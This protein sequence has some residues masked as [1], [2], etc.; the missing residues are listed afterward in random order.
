[1]SDPVGL[2]GTIGT[3][4]AV[5]IAVVALAGILPAYLL[6]KKSRTEIVQ[7]LALVDDPTH[8]FISGGIRL[9][10]S[11][12]TRKSKCPTSLTRRGC[13][14]SSLSQTQVDSGPADRPP[15]GSTSHMS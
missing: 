3:W 4:V 15:T 11:D 13:K 9:Q 12:S 14:A 5:F 8:S 6:Y 1:M 2:A 7:A 10:A